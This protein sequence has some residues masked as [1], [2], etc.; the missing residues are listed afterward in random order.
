MASFDERLVEIEEKWNN[1]MVDLLDTL[2]SGGEII[3]DSILDAFV[4]A[5]LITRD[6]ADQIKNSTNIAGGSGGPKAQDPDEEL[7]DEEKA[8]QRKDYLETLSGE[9]LS[10]RRK[11]DKD[12]EDYI[13]SEEIR[14]L[15]DDKKAEINAFEDNEAKEEYFK[16]LF[17]GV[18]TYE[19][20]N[21]KD[22]GPDSYWGV[23]NYLRTFFED[24]TLYEVK[25]KFRAKSP[26]DMSKLHTGLNEAG[27]LSNKGIGGRNSFTI[28][29]GKKDLEE[30]YTKDRAYNIHGL[31]PN[32][33]ND[34]FGRLNAFKKGGLI[35]Y[36]GLALV[37]GSSK[38]PEMVLSADQ[39]KMFMGLRDALEAGGTAGGINIGT[40]TIQTNELN[41]AQDFGKAGRALAAE[42]QK[43]IIRRGITINTKR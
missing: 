32:L 42:L 1:V 24:S 41:N 23:I 37:H 11:L 38:D 40:I 5:G 9:E 39:T 14:G 30:W 28:K 35:D 43:A 36:T 12:H 4:E 15:S 3:G 2:S 10:R 29:A 7:T 26:G 6:E 20:K 19:F 21:R 27:L 25:N 13:S 31:P 18:L 17:A 22:K 16:D 8:Q 33:Y 34:I